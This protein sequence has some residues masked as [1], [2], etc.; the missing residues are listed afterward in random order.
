[1]TIDITHLLP[2]GSVKNTGQNIS[3]VQFAPSSGQLKRDA[4]IESAESAADRS[5]KW[6][7]Q[8]PHQRHWKSTGMV[9]SILPERH[10]TPEPSSLLMVGAGLLGLAG[11]SLRKRPDTK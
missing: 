9:A 10:R 7:R 2:V 3:G 6:Y 4:R 8:Q 5:S 1:M 11:F